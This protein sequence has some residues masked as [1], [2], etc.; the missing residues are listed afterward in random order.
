[1]MGCG[2]DGSGDAEGGGS[3][4]GGDG[5]GDADGDGE[6]GEFGAECPIEPGVWLPTSNEGAPVATDI[7]HTAWN[8]SELLVFGDAGGGVYDP[9]ADSWTPIDMAGAPPE[10]LA[11]AGVEG[12]V[13]AG[14]SVTF[15]YLG[16]L[17]VSSPYSSTQ[18]GA[19]YDPDAA[20]WRVLP[21]GGDA[22]Q[23]RQ[24]AVI[25][26]GAEHVIVW[27]GMVEKEVELGSVAVALADGA[28]LDPTSGAWT[29]MPAAGAPSPRAG[30]AW[31]WAGKELAVWGGIH[32]PSSPFTLMCNPDYGCGVLGDG[33]LFD[34]VANRWRPIAAAGAPSPRSEMKVSWADERLV[35][36][37]GGDLEGS[38][39]DGALYDPT[40]DT[41]TPMAPLPTPDAL[42]G[43]INAYAEGSHFVLVA[44]PAAYIYDLASDTWASVDTSVEPDRTGFSA[45]IHGSDGRFVAAVPSPADLA[46]DAL[47]SIS[48][49][50][51]IAARW[52]KAPLP[53]AGRPALFS[54]SMA[55][56]GDRIVSWGGYIEVP[57]PN[58]DDGCQDGPNPC[59]PV[60]PTMRVY[61][62]GGG[63]T[64]PVFVP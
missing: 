25:T 11:H 49:I 20:K 31:A 52:T 3:G 61:D 1:M 32:D 37:G 54:G 46:E 15:L 63:M 47:A 50:D 19:V 33:A 40:A 8:G 62:Q 24:S 23:P 44:S 22:P 56:T 27:G 30:A 60:I 45:I 12:I 21:L 53:V 43:W 26:A 39:Y 41:W 59:D 2:G 14:R 18:T 51:V 9:C 5:S 16:A 6:S 57:D 48:R 34:P 29:P 64:A 36:W 35:V 38:R 4:D 28:M 10:L 17:G 7:R 55:W 58:G 42:T 13:G